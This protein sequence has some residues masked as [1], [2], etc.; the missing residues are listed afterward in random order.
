MG[1][2]HLQAVHESNITLVNWPPYGCGAWAKRFLVVD[3]CVSIS[4]CTGN[5][6]N[7]G[8]DLKLAFLLG[9]SQDLLTSHGSKASR[10]SQISAFFHTRVFQF[11]NKKLLQPDIRVLDV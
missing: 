4:L 8:I 2:V 11:S 9:L 5:A 10:S 1:L 3:L 7:L 6:V